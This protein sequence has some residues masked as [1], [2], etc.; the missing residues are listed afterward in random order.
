MTNLESSVIQVTNVSPTS[1]LEQMT[2]FF[3]F[4]GPVSEVV[5]YPKEDSNSIQT[6]SKTCYVRFNEPSAVKVAQHL[7]NTVFIDRALIVTPVFDN[8]IPD[9]CTSYS[10]TSGLNG[11]NN[12]GL[13]NQV[14]TGNNGIQVISTIDPRLSALGLPQYPGLPSNTDPNRIEEIR[15][16]VQ[17]TNLDAT[18]TGEDVLRFFNQIGEV[19]YV[20]MITN[21]NIPSNL[22]KLQIA[23]VEFTEQSTVASA[24]QSN[25][26]LLGSLPIKVSHCAQSI[27]K[28]Y[29]SRGSSNQ[30]RDIEEA[31]RRV[32]DSQQLTIEQPGLIKL[33]NIL[34]LTN[35]HNKSI[36][37][38]AAAA[39]DRRSSRSRSRSRR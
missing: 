34:H 30:Q 17:I 7:S 27:V 11:C 5:I 13:V 6:Q 25:S 28:P 31:M 1:S 23:L 12:E 15:R 4:V 22:T 9:E 19:K 26:S 21:D 16:T 35:E 8:R 39:A 10:L 3:S 20:R 33:E 36:N 32:R 2:N 18:V 29:G 24:L 37:A 14:V 38:V